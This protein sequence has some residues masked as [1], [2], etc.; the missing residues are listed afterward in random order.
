MRKLIH[1]AIALQIVAMVMATTWAQGTNP[2]TVL[3][4]GTVFTITTGKPFVVA[5]VLDAQSPASP[6]DPTLV[7]TRVNGFRLNVDSQPVV[8]ITPAAGAPCPAGNAN[9]GKLPYT[10]T[11]AS[12]V[13]KGNHTVTVK[14]WNYTLDAAGNPT[15]T[16][17]EGPAVTTPFVAAD[18]LQTGPPGGVSGVQVGR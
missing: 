14:A 18:V 15:T 12:G 17:Q 5:W 1:A 10:Y 8:E 6:T 3:P 7:P 11:T 4:P 2:C 9:A 13:A 16:K